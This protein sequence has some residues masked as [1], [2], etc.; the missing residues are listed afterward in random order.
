M[1]TSR[2]RTKQLPKVFTPDEIRALMATPNLRAPTGLRDRCMLEVMH[3]CGL[4]VSEVCGLHLRDISWAENK[5]NL[6]GEITKGGK[7]AVAYLDET[8]E[9]LLQQWVAVRAKY[10]AR[11]PHLFT[12]LQGD[13]VDRR[14]VWAMIRRRARKAG[15]DRD[16]YPHMLRHTYATELLREGFDVREV[17]E[18]L[19]HDD[20]RTTVIYTHLESATLRRKV[21]ARQRAA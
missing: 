18:L 10:A 6:R 1:A 2:R 8:T 16:V 5:I 19:R 9:A 21:R 3:R 17:Q 12:T 15:I 20:I 11:R 14:C 13:A 7:D 4:R